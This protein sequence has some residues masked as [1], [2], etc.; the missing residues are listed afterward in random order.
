MFVFVF[1]LYCSSSVPLVTHFKIRSPKAIGQCCKRGRKKVFSKENSQSLLLFDL[2]I[3][4][5]IYSIERNVE[6][7]DE[8]SL[9]KWSGEEK[10][11]RREEKRSCFAAV[12]QDFKS[13]Q[14]VR[15][16]GKG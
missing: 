4:R 9:R 8:T 6:N 13:V 16:P 3:D 10:R 14:S 7:I 1:F 11:R 12:V 2:L 5:L 15:Q